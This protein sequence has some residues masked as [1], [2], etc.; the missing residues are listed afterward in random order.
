MEKAREHGVK[1]VWDAVLNHKTAGDETEACW[2]VEVDDGGECYISPSN[3]N[4]REAKSET[5]KE[6]MS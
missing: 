5:W 2:A 6:N 4:P 1:V 3:P